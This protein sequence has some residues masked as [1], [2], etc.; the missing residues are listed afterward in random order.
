MNE[1]GQDVKYDCALTRAYEKL[2]HLLETDGGDTVTFECFK[3]GL[4]KTPQF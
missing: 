3:T 4:G 2:K 1:D